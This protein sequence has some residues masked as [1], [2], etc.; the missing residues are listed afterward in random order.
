MHDDRTGEGASRAASA[1]RCAHRSAGRGEA[2]TMTAP[3]ALS[4]F[5]LPGIEIVPINRQP[6]R[7]DVGRHLFPI[8][9]LRTRPEPR[10]KKVQAEIKWLHELYAAE[11]E[12][13]PATLFSMPAATVLRGA[14][15]HDGAPVEGSLQPKRA[16]RPD[17]VERWAHK[18]GRLQRLKQV[19]E[20]PG[21]SAIIHAAGYRNYYHW[22]I[23]ILP[24]LF[25][26]REVLRQGNAPFDRIVLFYDDP[27]RF[28]GSSIEWLLPELTPLIIYSQAK[29]SL[30]ERCLFFVDQAAGEAFRDHKLL[31]TR[32]KAATGFLTEAVDALQ[33]SQAPRTGGGRAILVSRS[34]APKRKLLN[35]EKLLEAFADRGLE[36]VAFAGLS[37]AQQMEVMA[38][39]SLVI[40]AHGAGLTNVL[41][42]RPGTTLIEI[43]ASDYVK[44]CRSFADIAM[45]RGLRY[46]LAMVD[47]SAADPADK[48]A[49]TDVEIAP[50]ALPRLRELAASLAGE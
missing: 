7:G 38:G 11:V 27:P 10:A 15:W 3:E 16:K 12:L 5:R 43:T 23:E 37:V 22:T 41:Y 31:S 28:I 19:E 40:G 30:M 24:R 21:T 48:D 25:A 1:S 20:F 46:G 44:R 18:L 26:L 17:A 8:L 9:D 42:C 2:T 29:V 13:R 14:V 49:V 33:A 35:E 39:A 45:Y 32:M 47:R 4:A 6:L 50:S 36:R 34:D